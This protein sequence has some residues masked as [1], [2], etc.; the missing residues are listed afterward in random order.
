MKNEC[1]SEVMRALNRHF[2]KTQEQQKEAENN[3][4]S[5]E[6]NEMQAEYFPKPSVY[7]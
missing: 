4:L 1:L 3:A 6:E 7:I 5:S 2:A